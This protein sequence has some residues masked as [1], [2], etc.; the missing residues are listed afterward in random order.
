M[1]LSHHRDT[2][3]SLLAELARDQPDLPLYTFL[4]SVADVSAVLTC[5]DLWHRAEEIA[6]MLQ[7][8][9]I[10]GEP[11]MV[12][13]P[14]GPDAIAM[15]FGVMMASCTPV[16]VTFH[17]RLGMV[18]IVDIIAHT[19]VHVV[20]GRKTI[21]AKL[22]AGRFSS[23]PRFHARQHP[24]LYLA[25]DGLPGHGRPAP[26]PTLIAAT[27]AAMI[28][29]GLPGDD[30]AAPV[31]LSHA[32]LLESVDSLIQKLA[33]VAAG[34]DERLLTALDLSDGM[35]LVLH[36]LLPLRARVVSLYYPVEQALRDAT[37][38]LL[39]ASQFACTII[40]APP[41]VLSL[42]A[43]DNGQ[44]DKRPPSHHSPDLS[45]LRFVC[46]DGGL[47][48][49]AIFSH[50]IERYRQNHMS[51]EKIFVCYGLSATAVVV[52]AL[53][54]YRVVSHAGIEALAPGVPN[55]PTLQA[56]A[57]GD[58]L[59]R[60]GNGF[61]FRGRSN[62]RFAVGDCEFQAEDIESVV[63][64][65]F[66]ALGLSRCI[67]LRLEEMQHTVVLAECATP[68]VANDWQGVV[69]AIMD[70]VRVDTGCRLDRVILLRPGSLP[71]AVSGL[72]LRQR[73]ASAVADGSLMLRLLPVRGK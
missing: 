12:L 25:I 70:A 15:L 32:E 62:H 52:A 18:G 63:L 73:C 54:G 71:L 27:G 72:V 4:D 61:Y 37:P 11:V 55:A 26:D 66:G 57:T 68:Q 17:R 8:Q 39:A 44:H 9:R 1:S 13:S 3:V 41:S 40:S 16:P 60:Q 56:L 23:K 51:P 47:A 43:H 5:Q 58:R 49:P 30:T 36:V 46:V 6:G 69:S 38:W 7:A 14:Y 29:P 48:T 53:Q 24:L 34:A 28:Y 31:A 35:A 50:F 33:L 65:S 20:I 21:L 67:V 2:F 10:S 59:S 45:T 64:Q 22:K 19:G 42:A